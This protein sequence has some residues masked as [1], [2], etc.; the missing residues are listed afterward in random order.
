[1]YASL[2]KQSFQ[3]FEWI[4]VDD[5]STD[6][7]LQIIKEIVYLAPFNIKIKHIKHGHK[8]I[9]LYHGL[10]LAAGFMTVVVDADDWIKPNALDP[11]YNTWKQYG[12]VNSFVGIWGLYIDQHQNLVGNKFSES[13]MICNYLEMVYKYKIKGEKYACYLTNDFV[14]LYPDYSNIREHIPEGVYHRKLARKK[15]IF[16]NDILRIYDTSTP[17]SIMKEGLGK[18]G[19]NAEG[20]CFEAM[21]LLN[22]YI[23]YFKYAPVMYLFAAARLNK[24]LKYSQTKKFKI[25]VFIARILY[26][27]TLPCRFLYYKQK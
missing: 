21:D 3:D 24:Y 25:C 13:P 17:G 8:K 22:N 18:N 23:S 16:I 5:G 1:M 2:L 7:T 10:H 14:K 6:D 4:I 11:F 15:I 27:C 26:F 9:A 19:E 12:D 20:I